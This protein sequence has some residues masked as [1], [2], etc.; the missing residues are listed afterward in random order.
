MIQAISLVDGN[1]VYDSLEGAVQKGYIRYTSDGQLLDVHPTV[2]R[3]ETAVLDCNGNMVFEHDIVFH[4][5][6]KHMVVYR[7]CRFF[8][9]KQDGALSE[10]L[11]SADVTICGISPQVTSRLG[12]GG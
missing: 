9:K 7:R 11:P 10:L 2:L 3:H 4:N 6:E 1:L 8:L 5:G 12:V